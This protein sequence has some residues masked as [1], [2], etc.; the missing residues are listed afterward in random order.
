M[1][2]IGK[3]IDLIFAVVKYFIAMLFGWL[4]IL[5]FLQ[6]FNR[7]LLNSALAWSEEIANY[8]MMWIALLGASMLMRNRGHMAVNNLLDAS[9]GT[10]KTMMTAISVVLQAIFLCS[11]IY[12]CVVFL[13]T[14]KGMR[15]PAT[16]LPMEIVDSVFLISGILMLIGLFDY[17]VVK[18]GCEAAYSEEDEMLRKIQE[19]QMNAGKEE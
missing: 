11:W 8:T 3:I 15:S 9:K 13:P 7:F 16:R 5:V 19:E 18:K 14:V 4:V 12:G 1:K 17:W 6:V 2:S 10:V